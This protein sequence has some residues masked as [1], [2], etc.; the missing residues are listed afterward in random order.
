[1]IAFRLES[2]VN[3][4]VNQTFVRWICSHSLSSGMTL[5]PRLNLSFL[6]LRMS[7]K[8]LYQDFPFTNII[9]LVSLEN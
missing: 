9:N 2:L 3:L 4:R 8:I 5:F 7:L 6:P 1:M